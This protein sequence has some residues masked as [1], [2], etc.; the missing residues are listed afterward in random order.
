MRWEEKA[1]YI[2]A[3]EAEMSEFEDAIRSLVLYL[4]LMYLLCLLV[5]II[6]LSFFGLI[7]S[8]LT[9]VLTFEL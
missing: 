1:T 4:L 6:I 2:L 3:Q 8:L 9:L 5:S 7:F